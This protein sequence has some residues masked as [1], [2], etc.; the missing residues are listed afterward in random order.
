MKYFCATKK[1]TRIGR[2]AITETAIIRW[3]WV[4]YCVRNQRSP[5]ARVSFSGDDR[6]MNGSKK[7]FQAPMNDKTATVAIAGLLSGTRICQ[8]ICQEDAPSISA[9]SSSSRGSVIRNW[10]IRK[11]A[12]AAP[13]KLGATRASRCRATPSRGT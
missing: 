4:S 5:T 8:R 3:N 1:A 13:K 11:M 12:K 9:A 2:T 6:K 10:R 7:S